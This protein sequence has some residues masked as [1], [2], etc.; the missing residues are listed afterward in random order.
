MGGLFTGLVFGIV[1]MLAIQY[2]NKVI[3]PD[4][5]ATTMDRRNVLLDAN[6]VT[7]THSQFQI[8]A[9][10]ADNLMG[11]TGNEFDA[12]LEIQVTTN[13]V[14]GFS[15]PF[16][17]AIRGLMAAG[18]PL[19]EIENLIS[20]ELD[21]IWAKE[22]ASTFVTADEEAE[23]SQRKTSIFQESMT[24]LL[25]AEAFASWDKE[26]SLRS[27]PSGYNLTASQSNDIYRLQKEQIARKDRLDQAQHS[28]EIDTLDYNEQIAKSEKQYVE[29]LTNVLANAQLIQP[30]DT[31]PARMQ[32]ETRG[33]NLTPQQL[34]DLID[35]E[36]KHEQAREMF[37]PKDPNNTGDPQKLLSVDEDAEQAWSRI[38]GPQV[39]ADYNRRNDYAYQQLKLYQKRW[40]LSDADIDYLEQKLDEYYRAIKEH[41]ALAVS[42]TPGGQTDTA[43]DPRVD[44]FETNL[45]KQL[46]TGIALSFGD[47]RLKRFQASGFIPKDEE[48]PAPVV[49]ATH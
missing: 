41:R 7:V 17:K 43:L 25:G 49:T 22:D 13:M 24:G 33:L 34:A 23:F 35:V 3:F 18:E 5:S 36:R 2:W 1:A 44:N 32:A 48:Q 27:I 20:T 46:R 10:I 16:V 8:Q 28:G 21:R 29:E 42:N 39:Y 38:L 45:S 30:P 12:A 31:L 11:S 14:I 26:D 37:G 40:N 47:D 15:A 4:A 9:G 19:D 6:S